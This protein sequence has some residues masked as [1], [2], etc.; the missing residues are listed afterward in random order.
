MR[1]DYLPFL[2]TKLLSPMKLSGKDGI[3]ETVELLDFYGFTKDDLME[4]LHELQFLSEQG[5]KGKWK[6]SCFCSGLTSQNIHIK[7]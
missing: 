2:R 4:S 6:S 1:L 3:R 7:R 5:F